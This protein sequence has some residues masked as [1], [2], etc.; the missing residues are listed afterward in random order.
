MLFEDEFT[1]KKNELIKIRSKK[2]LMTQQKKK[3]KN[4]SHP[5]INKIICKHLNTQINK[6]LDII[7][8]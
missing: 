2:V 4:F 5:R 1:V 7:F 3:K 6:A 8:K